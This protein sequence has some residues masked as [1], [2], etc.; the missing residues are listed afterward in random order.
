MLP[1][2]QARSPF[3][4]KHT[5]SMYIM[6]VWMV[7]MPFKRA[8]GE[9]FSSTKHGFFGLT[10]VYSETTAL[11]KPYF[12][13]KLRSVRTFLRKSL[14]FKKQKVDSTGYYG[15]EDPFPDLISKLLCFRGIRSADCWLSRVIG[16]Q[17]AIVL[18]LRKLLL[19]EGS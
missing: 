19:L 13:L 14:L 17:N 1:N 15:I 10:P 4:L 2:Y 8:R 6:C 3:V 18:M 7:H 5:T 9:L 11:S 16:S 12:I